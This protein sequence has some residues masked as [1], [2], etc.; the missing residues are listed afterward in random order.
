M[1][2]LL[3]L[4]VVLGLASL[5]P[6]TTTPQS[7]SITIDGAVIDCSRIQELGID[8]QAN[9]R[10]ARIRVLCGLESPGEPAAGTGASQTSGE[11]GPFAN[12]NTITGTETYPSVTQSE[13][14]V[15]SSDGNTIVVNYNDSRTAPGN[16]SG[17]SVSTDGGA[18]FSR[19]GM[20]QSPF[21]SGHGT[22]YGDPIVVYNARLSTWFAGDLATGCG[23]QGI[24]LWTSSDGS[25]WSVG[26]CAHNGGDDDRESMW[27]DNNPTSPFY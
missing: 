7:R 22:N 11:A 3:A 15:W 5:L 27:V 14:M 23:G 20:N 8:R 6:T 10:A 25:N 2:K 16:Y 9:L 24:G 18:S 4:P 26:A 13:S 19:L 12:V 21:A 1:K 17:V